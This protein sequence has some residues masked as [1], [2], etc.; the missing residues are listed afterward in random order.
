MFCNRNRAI[1]DPSEKNKLRENLCI[2]LLRMDGKNGAEKYIKL[3]VGGHLFQTTIDTL[4]R[5]DTM[6]S[7]MFSGRLDS[8][9]DTEGFHLIDRSGKL[10]SYVLGRSEFFVYKKMIKLFRG[11]SGAS[12]TIKPSNVVQDFNKT[13][14]VENRGKSAE[15]TPIRPLTLRI[16]L[17]YRAPC[18]L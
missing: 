8:M 14:L 12:V 7:A 16:L 5:G 1:F 10:F 2:N 13:T 11:F 18:I 9:Q 15:G 3:N 4:T 17:S 6:L